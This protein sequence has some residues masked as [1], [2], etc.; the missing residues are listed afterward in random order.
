MAKKVKYSIRPTSKEIIAIKPILP[1]VDNPEDVFTPSLS[2]I[3]LGDWID[4]ASLAS[5]EHSE[6]TSQCITAITGNLLTSLSTALKPVEISHIDNIPVHFLEEVPESGIALI[7]KSQSNGELMV[8]CRATDVHEAG[9]FIYT[10]GTQESVPESDD[11]NLE[12]FSYTLT[13]KNHKQITLQLSIELSDEEIDIDLPDLGI[14]QEEDLM[15]GSL[16]KTRGLL[17]LAAA[18][19]NK[20]QQEFRFLPIEQ[21]YSLKSLHLTAQNEFLLYE[22]SDHGTQLIAKQA[23]SHETVFSAKIESKGLYD[24][25]LHH[26]IDRPMQTNLMSGNFKRTKS[27]L[28][29][30]IK[31]KA[32]KIYDFSFY[33]KPIKDVLTVQ[34]LPLNQPLTVELWWAGLLIGVIQLLG[35]TLKGYHFTLE[36]QEDNTRLELK[37]ADNHVLTTQHLADHLDMASMVPEEQT[38]MRF[39]LGFENQ[40]GAQNQF[41]ITLNLE[42][43]LIVSQ[44]APYTITMDDLSPYKKIVLSDSLVFDETPATT[45]NLEKIFEQMQIPESHRQVDIEQLAN[46]NV[47]EVKISDNTDK[48]NAPIT[49]ADVELKFDGGNGG[50][51]MLYKYLAIDI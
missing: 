12:V 43:E 28:Y 10:L 41:P 39:D 4:P 9:D 45:L 27:S 14:I 32:G 49:V 33:F 13:D 3:E 37:L 35:E 18:S 36:G 24:F 48:F 17:P 50:L 46:S 34:A 2:F 42:H 30:D 15:M 44:G 6:S 26:P 19:K 29:Q 11:S 25:E 47:Y 20:T 51:E 1:F 16:A 8:F 31:T 38:Q 23:K 5:T 22:L 7:H 40:L 21:Q